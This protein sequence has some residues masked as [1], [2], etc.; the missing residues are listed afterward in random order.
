MINMYV[1]RSFESLGGILKNLSYFTNP[2]FADVLNLQRP[3]NVLIVYLNCP[4][5]VVT[6]GTGG[7]PVRSQW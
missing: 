1:H 7:E 6:G 5:P 2:I 3:A 4:L